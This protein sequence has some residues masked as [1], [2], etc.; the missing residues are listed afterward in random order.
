[1]T[2]ARGARRLRFDQFLLGNAPR[3]RLRRT[4]SREGNATENEAPLRASAGRKGA[5]QDDP[6][7]DVISLLAAGDD[8][9]AGAAGMGREVPGAGSSSPPRRHLAEGARYIDVAVLAELD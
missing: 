8:C 4:P 7:E 1:M 9:R 2:S 5:Q 3:E 6:G